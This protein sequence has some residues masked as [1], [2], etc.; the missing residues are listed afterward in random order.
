MKARIKSDDDGLFIRCDGLIGRPFTRND[1]NGKGTSHEKGDKVI[2]KH[3]P[4][5]ML[6]VAKDTFHSFEMWQVSEAWKRPDSAPET[7]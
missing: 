6:Y 7:L 4:G 2:V 5:S 1:G 3:P